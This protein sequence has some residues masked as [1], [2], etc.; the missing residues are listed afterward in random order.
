[1]NKKN[2]PLSVPNLKGQELELV[3]KAIKDEWVST[4]GPYVP[5]FENM[6]AEYVHTPDA[7]S[8]QNGTS[9][10]HMAMMLMGVKQGDLV[11]VPPLTFIAAVNPVKYVGADPVFIDCD[12]TLTMDSAKLEKFCMEECELKDGALFHRASR[13]RIS[14]LVVV[15]VFGNIAD[16]ESIMDIAAKY[17][18]KVIEDA[19]E[20]LGSYCKEG[21]YAGCFAGTI[22]DI[23]VFSYN[24][25]KIITTGGGGMI[26]SKD[27][28]LLKKAKHLV[29]QAKADTIYFV[30][31]MIGYNYRMTNL[32]AALGIAQLKQLEDFIKIKTDNYNLYKDFFDKIKGLKI[33]D[34]RPDIR[35]N[36][37]FYS[38]YIDDSFNIGRDDMIKYL[39]EKGIQTRPIWTLINDQV[40]YKSNISY[41]IE[42]A[43]YYQDRVVNIPCSTNLTKE[44]ALYVAETIAQA[45]A[46]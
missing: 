28:A 31:D 45:A 24:G 41:M 32:Q 34:F 25:N 12:D 14:A 40:M 44:D 33:L 38:L 19:T 43:R 23:G 15:H 5:E 10:L 13:K 3:S 21:R 42:K 7:V 46:L 18:L 1:M 8:C 6:T 2:I 26:V 37:W 35:S 29:N 11:I 22:G 20:A 17:R 30:H 39:A 4:G 9:G 36:H 27:E 16:M